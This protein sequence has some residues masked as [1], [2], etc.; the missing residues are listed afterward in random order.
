MSSGNH[1]PQRS[2]RIELEDGAAPIPSTIPAFDDDPGGDQPKKTLGPRAWIVVLAILVVGIVGAGLLALRPAAD[3]AADGTE[4]QAP[5]TTV[6]S[7]DESESTSSDANTDEADEDE[8]AIG[9]SGIV[10]TPLV[11]GRSLSQIIAADIGFIALGQN[12][13]SEPTILRS[14]DG[15]DW[16]DVDTTALIDGVVNTERVNWFNLTTFG[17]RLA[18]TGTSEF[19][20]FLPDAQ[21]FVSEAGAEWTAIELPGATGDPTSTILPLNFGEQEIFGV[22]FGGG[23]LVQE[24]LAETTT[25]DIPEEGICD[26]T[27]QNFTCLLY[28]SPS[29]RDQR[30]SRM[31]SSA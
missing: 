29:P 17:G 25:A 13:G 10:P 22:R 6:P 5:T 18:V 8:G 3:A 28:T 12:G 30:G 24:F 9:A 20:T 23:T 4:R 27:R 19:S 21:V 2:V 1:D 15:E 11:T 26:V 14:V 31:P 7:T 16:F